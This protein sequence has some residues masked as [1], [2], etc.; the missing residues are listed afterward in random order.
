ML[1]YLGYFSELKYQWGMLDQ[2][3]VKEGGCLERTLSDIAGTL[4]YHLVVWAFN[5]RKTISVVSCL[6]LSPYPRIGKH[7]AIQIVYINTF[8]WFFIV[9]QKPYQTFW[10][11][12]F[13]LKALWT[14]VRLMGGLSKPIQTLAIKAALVLRASC[15]WVPT[16]ANKPHTMIWY[17]K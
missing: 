16:F 12:V 14:I 17:L 7:I 5:F 6:M 8:V 2:I 13:L 9:V 1:L 10:I 11:L 15:P 3:S 4:F